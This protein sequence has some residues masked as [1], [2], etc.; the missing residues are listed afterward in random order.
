MVA[1]EFP[2]WWVYVVGPVLGAVAGS[3]LWE[4]LLVQGSKEA[5]RAVGKCHS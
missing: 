5:M 1:V 2:F 4:R 3:V